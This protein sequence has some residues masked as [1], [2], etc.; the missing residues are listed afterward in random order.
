MLSF[1]FLLSSFY[2]FHISEFLLSLSLSLR[3]HWEGLTDLVRNYLICI[4]RHLCHVASIEATSLP[5]IQPVDG[6]FYK[7]LI[8]L[9]DKNGEG[10]R[11]IRNF[12]DLFSQELQ[13]YSIE[14]SCIWLNQPHR[15]EGTKP[16]C[17][18]RRTDSESWEQ[19]LANKYRT[20]VKCH[21]RHSW[22][23][24]M[25]YEILRHSYTKKNSLLIIHSHLAAILCNTTENSS[26]VSKL[27]LQHLH[28]ICSCW[29]TYLLKVS[30]R[31]WTKHTHTLRRFFLE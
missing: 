1:C 13:W 2:C 22:D 17:E 19:I 10:N 25:S 12:C 26:V 30:Q 7:N 15:A 28:P 29:N 5:P 24:V 21:C 20:P 31:S 27:E 18:H 16:E 14:F 4:N 9:Q 23:T 6:H 11:V 3:V 8:L